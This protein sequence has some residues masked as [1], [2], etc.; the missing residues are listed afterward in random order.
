MT[1][2]FQRQGSP[3]QLSVS[4]RDR[5]RTITAFVITRSQCV[6]NF[7][8]FALYCYNS[9]A[10][11]FLQLSLSAVIGTASN[12]PGYPHQQ[13]CQCLS[14]SCTPTQSLLSFLLILCSNMHRLV[15]L[16]VTLYPRDEPLQGLTCPSFLI[17]LHFM[18]NCC[19][20]IT[21]S[22]FVFSLPLQ[23]LTLCTLL[24]TFWC[25]NI[26]ISTQEWNCQHMFNFDIDTKNSFSK[27]SYQLTSPPRTY[28]GAT[29]H[30]QQH[31]VLSAFPFSYSGRCGMVSMENCNLH[32][33]FW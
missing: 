7:L 19:N 21:K 13:L 4:E 17:A 2:S 6:F 29:P 24:H 3:I 30:S 14:R 20:Y 32:L 27:L 8:I 9:C 23:N 15:P 22:C 25:T 16:I 26:H 10:S 5:E 11:N 33:H 31:V 28:S 1:N 18:F 12:I